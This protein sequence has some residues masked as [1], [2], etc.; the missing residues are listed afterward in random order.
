MQVNPVYASD[1]ARNTTGEAFGDPLPELFPKS[2]PYCFQ[3]PAQGSGG[4]VMPPALCGTDWLPYTQS[5]RDAARLTRA[6][7]DGAKTV[8]D[9]FAVSADKVYKASGPQILGTRT[10]LSLTDSASAYQYGIQMA[11]LSR[12]GDNGPDRAFVAPDAAGLTAGVAA[13][14]ADDGRPVLEPDPAAAGPDAYPLTVLTYA[15]VAPLSLDEA[16]RSDYAEFLRYAAGP[17]QVLGHELGQLPP[18]YA[19]LPDELRAQTIAAALAVTSLKPLAEPDTG[20]GT[21]TESEQPPAASET[22]LPPVDNTPG[23]AFQPLASDPAPAAP[24]SAPAA[25]PTE[26]T[27]A[28]T[29][30]GVLTPIVSLAGNRLALPALAVIALLSALGIVEI[31][32]RPRRLPAGAAAQPERSDG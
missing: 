25:L 3:A 14:A 10:I 19:P 2:D 29:A 28:P 22:A 11:R 7:D 15:A 12:A 17:G 8:N 24:A 30:T 20:A 13:M 23:A 26:R 21:D 16:A 4:T 32:K 27:S 6:A 1:P 5:L 9:R 31:T 18:G